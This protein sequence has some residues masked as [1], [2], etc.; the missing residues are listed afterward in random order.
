MATQTAMTTQTGASQN[1]GVVRSLLRICLVLVAA[2]VVVVTNIMF[3]SGTVHAAEPPLSAA[4]TEELSAAQTEELSAAQTEDRLV[5]LSELNSQ[6]FEAAMAAI[7]KYGVETETGT[8]FSRVP[9]S[10]VST[11]DP[12]IWTALIEHA[13]ATARYLEGGDVDTGP[14]L[15]PF[16][17]WVGKNWRPIK[18]AAVKSGKW[19]WYKAHR[20][21]DGASTSIY[22][23]TGENPA[24]TTSRPKYYLDVSIKGCIQRL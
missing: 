23:A 9:K 8:D 18:D 13:G 11:L 3:S 2:V 5:F 15:R 12:V 22:Y 1:G 14:E 7:E 24:L 4:Q 16:F 17:Q 20:C 10:V 21:A 6:A 19:A